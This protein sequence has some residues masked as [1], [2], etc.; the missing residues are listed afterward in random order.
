MEHMPHLSRP[1]AKVLA[2]FSFGM[3]I[4]KSCGLT[5]VSV[6]LA[7]Q[8]DMKENT[9]RQRLREW[10]WDAEDKRGDKRQSLDVSL[11][12]APL[13]MW[14]LSLW[15]SSEK[16][17]ALAM[18]ATSL[19][20]RF[21]VLTI[22]VIYRSCAIPVAWEILPATQSEAWRDHWLRLFN[23]LKPAIPEEWFVVVL[24]DRGLYAPW[25][26]EA[27]CKQG[28]HPFLRIN[29]QGKYRRLD[30][31][32][33]FPLAT[34]CPKQGS[35]F[36]E[37]VVCFKNNSLHATLLATWDEPHKD[38][39]LILTD[40]APHE[41]EIAWYGLRFWIEC[42]FKHTKRAGWQWQNTRM[43]SPERA[44]RLWLAIAVA[45]LWSVS[46]GSEAEDTL[47]AS[48]LESLPENHI[49]LRNPP[50][51]KT[52]PRLISCFRRGI[53]TILN[54]LIKHIRLPIGYLYQPSWLTLKT[55][56]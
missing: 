5:S 40:L 18:D 10:C 33:F 8:L 38:P 41:A 31:S 25:L 20:Q 17:I 11:S 35:T 45:T 4:A 24:A 23:L 55:Y 22:S 50:S 39:W 28:W 37:Q 43:T 9:I 1:Q 2:W 21:V 27:I 42:G 3:E 6:V 16:R 32:Q 48:D 47:P 34:I 19:G 54:A 36:A 26:F 14:V 51:K 53:L 30:S 44:K 49:A 29:M 46:V 56:P 7:R 12:F 13:L 52:R 15:R